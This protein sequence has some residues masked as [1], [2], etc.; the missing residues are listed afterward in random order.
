[1]NIDVVE[2]DTSRKDLPLKNSTLI[3]TVVTLLPNY[4]AE[5][6]SLK[7]NMQNMPLEQ[8]DSNML[9]NV[10]SPMKINLACQTGVEKPLMAKSE[11][12]SNE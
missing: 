10:E 8:I 12:V 7:E 6:S 4:Q 1:M 11:K 2:E 3:S 9:S 5:N